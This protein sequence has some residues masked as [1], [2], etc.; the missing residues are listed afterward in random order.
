MCVEKMSYQVSVY[1]FH[2][3]HFPGVFQNMNS[4]QSNGKKSVNGNER[5]TKVDG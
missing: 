2:N 4:S 5:E 1:L 3:E